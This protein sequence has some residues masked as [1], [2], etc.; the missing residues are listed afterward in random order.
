VF[1]KLWSHKKYHDLKG[2]KSYLTLLWTTFVLVFLIYRFL[3]NSKISI[4]RV[5]EELFIGNFVLNFSMVVKNSFIVK[6]CLSTQLNNFVIEQSLGFVL[7][8]PGSLNRIQ[9]LD[10]IYPGYIL[11]VL[12]T[13]SIIRIVKE[14]WFININ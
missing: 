6:V 1:L 14:I 5:G 11:Y 12:S 13:I 4:L 9:L 7:Y 3:F 10:I 8:S 2:Q